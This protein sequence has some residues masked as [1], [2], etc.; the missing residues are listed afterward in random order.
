MTLDFPTDFHS[1]PALRQNCVSSLFIYSRGLFNYIFGVLIY[2]SAVFVVASLVHVLQNGS[3][4][5]FSRC[6][7]SFPQGDSRRGRFA[8]I[9]FEVY[10]EFRVSPDTAAALRYTEAWS[11]A[12]G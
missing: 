3:L 6:F 4:S 12:M 7:P 10:R 2:N 9:K 1:R 11:D 8:A 5:V